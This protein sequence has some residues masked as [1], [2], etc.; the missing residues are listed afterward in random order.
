MLIILFLKKDI[1]ISY[2][3]L[4]ADYNATRINKI[5]FKLCYIK[6]NDMILIEN[7]IVGLNYYLYKLPVYNFEGKLISPYMGN[8]FNNKSSILDIDINFINMLEIKNYIS[9]NINKNNS[10]Y[11]L[12]DVV[13]DLNPIGIIILSHYIIFI[14]NNISFNISSELITKI[15]N[16]NKYKY[17]DNY[18]NFICSD[19]NHNITDNITDI[20]YRYIF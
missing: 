12:S 2:N 9:P 3:L 1:Y 14:K 17:N 11:N 16:T 5:N 8:L 13:N 10:K 19:K 4:Y 15:N 20:Y 6:F 7:E 18:K